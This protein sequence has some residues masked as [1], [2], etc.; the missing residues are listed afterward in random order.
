MEIKPAQRKRLP[1]FL[2]LWGPSNSGKTYS[3]LLVARGLVGPKGKIG[4]IDT[5][6]RRAEIYDKLVGG[7]DHID[8]QPPFTPARYL[9]AFDLFK[10]AGGYGCVIFDSASHV[11]SGEG[12]IVDVG[13]RNGNGLGAW[14]H[15]IDYTKMIGI[16][17]RSNIHVIFNLRAKDAS[18]QKGKTV[19][20]L[21]AQPVCGKDFS[22]IY[23]MTASVLLG[24]DKTPQF[25]DGS[26]L[27]DC[28][29]ILPAV[30]ETEGLEG[31]LR[32]GERLSIDTGERLAKWSAGAAAFDFDQA[33]LERVA[34]DV[35][36]MGTDKYRMHW[37]TLSAEQKRSLLPM[38]DELKAIAAEADRQQDA[39]GQPA[40]GEP[41]LP[42]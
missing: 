1:V 27:I 8:L 2:S 36:T 23:D 12:G 26:Q 30:K 37:E 5:E 18:V 19:T 29:P 21:G 34:R 32:K 11:W 42:L 9:E 15:K 35:A 24:P 4:L 40:A 33:E 14:K 10:R 3:S 41:A 22:F 20:H 25:Q 16:L 13:T 6:N 17:L 31:L 28:N 7:W 39:A 38:R